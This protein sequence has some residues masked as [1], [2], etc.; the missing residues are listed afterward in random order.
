MSKA[1]ETTS[2]KLGSAPLLSTTSSG[3][4]AVSPIA[5]GKQKQTGDFE[6]VA[7]LEEATGM[8]D[9][10]KHT[11]VNV[12]TCQNQIDQVFSRTGELLEALLADSRQLETSKVRNAAA[13][14]EEVLKGLHKHVLR[15]AIYGRPK[16]FVNRE[17]ISGY[18]EGFNVEMDKVLKSFA[19]TEHSDVQNWEGEYYQA[20]LEDE[21]ASYEQ[22]WEILNNESDLKIIMELGGD[23]PSSLAKAIRDAISFPHTS[24]DRKKKLTNAVK[25]IEVHSSTDLV[26]MQPS[27][28]LSEPVSQSRLSAIKYGDSRPSSSTSVNHPKPGPANDSGESPAAKAKREEAERERALGGE[29]YDE[30]P[31]PRWEPRRP[32]PGTGPGVAGGTKVTAEVSEPPPPPPDLTDEAPPP[33]YSR[34]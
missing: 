10:I 13:S 32:P 25:N 28:L 26:L 4:L 23:A 6:M 3:S 19:V 17:E 34:I 30:A 31:L 15:F 7:Y 2:I 5:A 20:K 18:F 16:A 29:D 14:V 22:L 8:L 11:A 1:S 9:K 33:D 27:L 24:A 21:A 12:T